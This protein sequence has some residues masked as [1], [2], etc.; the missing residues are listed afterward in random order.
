MQEQQQQQKYMFNLKSHGGACSSYK[1]LE[2]SEGLS[3]FLEVPQF[4]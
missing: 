1:P 4:S 3:Q 2:V